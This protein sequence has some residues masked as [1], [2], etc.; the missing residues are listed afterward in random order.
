VAILDSFHHQGLEAIRVGRFNLGIN[1]SF[2]VMRLGGTVFDTGPSNQWEFVK[3]FIADKALK[4]LILTHHHE[5]HSGNAAAIKALTG[6]TP[7]APEITTS[8]LRK[9]F[10]IPPV[11]RMIWGASEPVETEVL[12]EQITLS[13]GESAEAIFAPGHA[14]DMTCYLLRER[15]W[16]LSADLYIANHLKFLRIDEHIPTIIDSTKRVLGYDFETILCPH[17]GIVEQGKQ[18]LAE[19]VDFLINL[20]G[21]TQNLHGQGYSDREITRKLLGKE[22]LMSLL[23]GYNFSK[24]NLVRSCLTVAL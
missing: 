13:N 5:D 23:S 16:L 7:L 4:Q 22:N 14:R 12:P 17:K 24:I 10:K 19:K 3:S 20:A 1:T 11:Q 15:G 8:I 9:G 6:V 2:I 21:E 18:R